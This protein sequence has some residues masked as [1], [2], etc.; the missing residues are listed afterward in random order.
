M[1][2]AVS[3]AGPVDDAISRVLYRACPLCDALLILTDVA[4][5]LL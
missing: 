5:V 3:E 4:G 1:S 2:E